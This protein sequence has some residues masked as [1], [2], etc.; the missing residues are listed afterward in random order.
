VLRQFQLSL[1]IDDMLSEDHNNSSFISWIKICIIKPYAYK[2]PHT[3][4]Y[5][6]KKLEI[7]EDQEIKF[8]LSNLLF[9]ENQK[10][11]SKKRSRNQYDSSLDPL[12]ETDELLIMESS[13]IQ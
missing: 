13:Q 10:P 2:I 5:L 9:D 8:L 6:A 7:A 4:H 12:K 1:D 3:I 11:M